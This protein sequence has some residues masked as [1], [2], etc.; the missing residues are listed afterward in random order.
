M[1]LGVD[2]TNKMVYIN[3]SG[4]AEQGKNMKVPLDVFMKA[5]QTDDF[6]MTVAERKAPNTSVSG[7]ESASISGSV[8][9]VSVA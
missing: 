2:R 8:V 3:D 1:I 6:E 9:L 7:P 5:W 4:F